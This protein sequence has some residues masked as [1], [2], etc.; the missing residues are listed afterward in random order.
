[1]VEEV[2]DVV[3]DQG[4]SEADEVVEEYAEQVASVVVKAVEAVLVVL[5][6]YLGW[7]QVAVFVQLELSGKLPQREGGILYIAPQVDSLLRYH[8][9]AN[10]SAQ[11]LFPKHLYLSQLG[12][13]FPSLLSHTK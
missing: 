1:M 9:P 8:R 7:R 5:E 6:V 4:E 12:I 2:F 13:H 3:F 10:Y 11:Q